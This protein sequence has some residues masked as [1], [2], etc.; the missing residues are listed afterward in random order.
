MKNK[1]KSYLGTG[2]KVVRTYSDDFHEKEVLELD[3][4]E[5]RFIL[6]K[7]NPFWS[8]KPHLHSLKSLTVHGNYNGWEGVPI[9]HLSHLMGYSVEKYDVEGEVI[10]GFEDRG[11][12]DSQGYEVTIDLNEWT[13]N[14]WYDAKDEGTLFRS[15]NLNKDSIQWLY[16]H[17]FDLH[18]LIGQG[19]A[20]EIGKG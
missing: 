6:G 20:V 14:V 8:I 12:D 7:K 3:L 5:T 15:H 17:H 2:L 10:Y 1:L 11:Y 19:D 9:I 16:D 4:F 18:N 13:F